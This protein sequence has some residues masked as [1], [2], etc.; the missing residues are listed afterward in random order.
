MSIL[1]V[2]SCIGGVGSILAYTFMSNEE[3][4]RQQ[5]IIENAE[6]VKRKIEE[7]YSLD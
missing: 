1:F 5:K 4:E 3:I 2:V 6:R 7:I